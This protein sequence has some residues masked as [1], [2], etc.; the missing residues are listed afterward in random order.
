M[1]NKTK[2]ALPGRQCQSTKLKP[3]QNS[4]LVGLVNMTE[5]EFLPRLT[6]ELFLQLLRLSLQI[7]R[8]RKGYIQNSRHPINSRCTD[9]FADSG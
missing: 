5:G 1:P 4:T 7:C 9:L 8:V 2:A 3:I 6:I